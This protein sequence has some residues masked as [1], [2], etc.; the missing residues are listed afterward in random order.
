MTQRLPALFIG[1]STEGLSTAYAIQ[2]AMEYDAEPTVWNQG[3]FQPSQSTLAAL[4]ESLSKFEFAAFVF[5]PDDTLKLRGTDFPAVRDNVIFELGL[6]MGALGPGRCFCLVPRNVESPRLPSDLAGF[7]TLTYNAARSDGNLLAA[8]GPA[9]NE[10]RN[11]IIKL[12]AAGT[13]PAQARDNHP[14]SPEAPAEKLQRYLVSWNG[15]VLTNARALVRSK[16]V[17][18]SVIE[19]DEESRPEWGAFQKIFYFLESLS[20]AILAKEIEADAARKIF[21][22][23]LPTVWKHACTA[24]TTPNHADDSWAP[25]PNIAQVSEMWNRRTS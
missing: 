15:E 4:V 11:A 18:M 12:H 3:V 20:A 16:G 19:V 22:D 7:T 2:Q 6:F 10:M 14:A 8:L 21:G 17:P 5:S 25:L 1:S 9:C 23:V 24:L 13:P